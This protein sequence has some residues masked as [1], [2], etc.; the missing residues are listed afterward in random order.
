MPCSLLQPQAEDRASVVVQKVRM[1]ACVASDITNSRVDQSVT[2]CT[3]ELPEI[4]AGEG[5]YSGAI[6]GKYAVLN[7]AEHRLISTKQP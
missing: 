1:I 3:L 2:A 6:F 7:D 5:S 4:Q